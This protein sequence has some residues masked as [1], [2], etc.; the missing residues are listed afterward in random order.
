MGTE[1]MTVESTAE[2]IKVGQFVRLVG[3]HERS[4]E[5]GTVVA[6]EGKRARFKFHFDGLEVTVPA[7][8][9]STDTL[10]V[11]GF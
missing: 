8:H 6:L 3:K 5:C 7:R 10:L 1:P 4:E 9:L 11:W 2:T